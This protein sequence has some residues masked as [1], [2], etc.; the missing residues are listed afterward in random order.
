MAAS[1][2]G[3]VVLAGRKMALTTGVLCDLEARFGGRPV[4]EIFD[5]P[6]LTAIRATIALATGVTEAE[7][8]EIMD[9]VGIEKAGAALS[10]AVAA[11]FPTA[12]AGKVGDADPQTAA[13][14]G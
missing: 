13:S 2:R 8:G 4:A 6:S 5:N 12:S 1:V 3:A 10:E 14:T 9:E 11:A 7:A